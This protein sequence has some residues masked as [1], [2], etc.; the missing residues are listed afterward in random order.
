MERALQ[1]AE[2][3]LI[4]KISF[5]QFWDSFWL[6]VDAA[7]TIIDFQPDL[8][9]II[10]AYSSRSYLFTGHHTDKHAKSGV[11]LTFL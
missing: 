10:Y 7:T 6:S 2:E 5:K 9:T 8:W 1:D 11:Q 3:Q 4:Y